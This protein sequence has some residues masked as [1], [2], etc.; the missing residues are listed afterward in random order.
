MAILNALLKAETNN[1]NTQL[2]L[3]LAWDR[4]EI[5]SVLLNGNTFLKDSFLDELALEAIV[6][7]QLEFFKVFAANGVDVKQVLTHR[8]LLKMYNSLSESSVLYSVL[9]KRRNKQSD[10]WCGEIFTFSEIGQFIEEL[11]GNK[12]KH[13]FTQSRL[14][15]ISVERTAEILNKKD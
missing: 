3:S 10:S 15:L 1:V 11:L 9:E 6:N 12:Y 5:A 8:R 7:N 14:C 4:I 2:K 13:K